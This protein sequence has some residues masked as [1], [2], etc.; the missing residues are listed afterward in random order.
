MWR[1]YNVIVSLSSCRH[2]GKNI[3]NGDRLNARVKRI[4][5]YE[6]INL[7]SQNSVKCP[8]VLN[9]KSVKPSR[10]CP[11]FRD[12]TTDISPT[13]VN[14]TDLPWSTHGYPFQWRS[15]ELAERTCFLVWKRNIWRI[16]F[17][18]NIKCHNDIN[19]TAVVVIA[20]SC[21]HK[22]YVCFSYK[23][24]VMARTST[25]WPH[26]HTYKLFVDTVAMAC[27]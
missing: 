9:S 4:L 6:C 10:N 21:H 23:S 5:Q 27:N 19:Q 13:Q 20:L 1:T 22:N 17:F 14:D 15:T 18:S 2:Y 26:S 24:P 7:V 8:R 11:K 3:E 25:T 12:P 16:C